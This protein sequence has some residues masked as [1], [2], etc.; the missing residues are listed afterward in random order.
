MT[1]Y[2]FDI[3]STGLLR[4]GSQIHCIVLRDLDNRRAKPLVF[5]TVQD[6][7]DEGIE[8]LQ[9]ADVLAGH[10]I[11]SYDISLIK[12]LYPKFKVPLKLFDTLILSRLYYSTLAD[13]DFRFRPFGLPKKLYGSHSL[14]AHGI[15]LGEH[16]GDFG[17][18]GS[19]SE[20]TPDM[21]EYCIQ[22]TTTNLALLDDLARLVPDNENPLTS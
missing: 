12:E 15:R 1:K 6:N 17:E 5:D 8:V 19:W 21:L 22:D 11:I 4:R 14:K 13:R 10:N 3:E 18:T 2:L 16:K 7:V 20:Y 9:Q